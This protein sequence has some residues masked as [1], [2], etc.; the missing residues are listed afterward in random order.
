MYVHPTT[1]STFSL[2]EGLVAP[3]DLIQALQAGRHGCSGTDRSQL[4]TGAIEFVTACKAAGIQSII[5]LERGLKLCWEST[6]PQ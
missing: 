3:K 6:T 2:Q 5:G 4:L 1:H